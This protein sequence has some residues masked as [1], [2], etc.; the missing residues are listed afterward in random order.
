MFVPAYADHFCARCGFPFR[1]GDRE[2]CREYYLFSDHGRCEQRLRDTQDL[3]RLLMRLR[4]TQEADPYARRTSPDAVAHEWMRQHYPN[5]D[6]QQWEPHKSDE[7]MQ[8]GQ[9]VWT[10]EEVIL[11]MDFYVE[12]GADRGEP[13][14]GHG[15]AEIVQLSS[16]LKKLAAYPPEFQDEKY[17]NRNGVYLKMMNLRAV[18]AEGE[19]GMNAYSQLDAAVWRVCER[20]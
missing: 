11:A 13:I 20:P 7:Q 2:Y 8:P 16:L 19:H 6:L 12:I 14:P 18:Q 1:E 3:E 15:A 17:R 9:L 10:R 4:K 5:L